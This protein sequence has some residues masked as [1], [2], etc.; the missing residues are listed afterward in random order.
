MAFYVDFGSMA[1]SDLPDTRLAGY[2][3]TES[4]L[5]PERVIQCLGGK[6]YGVRA[7][8][9]SRTASI[10][11]GPLMQKLLPRAEQGDAEAQLNL[12]LRYGRRDT[13]KMW[14]WMCRAANQGYLDA[15]TQLGVLYRHGNTRRIPRDTGLAYMWFSLAASKGDKV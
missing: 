9:V 15:Q 13:R 6:I 1:S 11:D 12:A 4:E 8:Q 7:C 5:R 2:Y 10:P 3:C 14:L